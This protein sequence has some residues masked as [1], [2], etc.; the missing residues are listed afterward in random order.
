MP[1]PLTVGLVA[2]IFNNLPVWA[3]R[4]LGYFAAADLDVTASVLYGVGN[5]TDAVRT[6]TAEVGVGTPES[7]LSDHDTHEGLI[8]VGGNARTL[9]NGLIARRGIDG[10]EQLRGA[11]IGVSH[12]T[13]GTA[14]LV[15]KMLAAHGLTVERD[16]HIAAIGVAS[17]R[18]EQIQQGTLDAGLQTPPHKYIAEELG[19]ANLGDIFDYVPDYQFTTLNAR[20]GWVR[21]NADPLRRFLSCLSLATQW[22]Y[23]EPGAAVDLASNVLLTTHDYAQRDYDHFRHSH[24][25]TADLQLSEPGMATVISMMTEAGT[26]AAPGADQSSRIRPVL[27]T[28]DITAGPS[29]LSMTPAFRRRIGQSGFSRSRPRSGPV[30]TWLI[31]RSDS[32]VWAG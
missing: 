27:P 9:N 2:P 21:G 6:G 23:D 20:R 31:G 15:M 10:I 14:L 16:Y 32:K 7:V 13:E 3:A 18:W 29:G 19:Y 5:V 12:R 25:L 22:M 17:E 8:M 24:S 4:E 1:E 30:S 28:L 11:T 26:L